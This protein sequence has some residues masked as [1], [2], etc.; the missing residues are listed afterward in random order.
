MYFTKTPQLH[1][2][3]SCMASVYNYYECINSL[4][5]IMLVPRILKSHFLLDLLVTDAYYNLSGKPVNGPLLE[6][7]Y[8]FLVVTLVLSAIQV[9]S[10]AFL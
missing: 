2:S 5:F 9:S 3:M 6:D 1:D 8:S 7:M 10:F 4:C